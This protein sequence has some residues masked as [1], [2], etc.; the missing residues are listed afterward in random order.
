MLLRLRTDLRDDAGRPRSSPVFGGPQLARAF[1]AI[2]L[3]SSVVAQVRAT[4]SGRN[5]SADATAL[6]QTPRS[7]C[8]RMLRPQVLVQGTS[9]RA[10]ETATA[11][12]DVDIVV[13]DGCWP[14]PARSQ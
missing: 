11:S 5:A 4:L 6:R 7:S 14:L 8:Y 3:G 2:E 9:P 10:W 12:D 13:I 1:E